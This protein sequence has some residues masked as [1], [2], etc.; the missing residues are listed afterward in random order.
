MAHGQFSR[1]ILLSRG[2]NPFQIL[3]EMSFNE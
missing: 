1:G 2:K 3:T